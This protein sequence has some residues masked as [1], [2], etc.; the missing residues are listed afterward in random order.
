[1]R[2]LLP[3]ELIAVVLIIVG[4]WLGCATGRVPPVIRG[5][6]VDARS[7]FNR[8]GDI[9]Y[10]VSLEWD[11]GEVHHSES[12]IMDFQHYARIRGLAEVC[13]YPTV[14]GLD[15]RECGANR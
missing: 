12:V 7:V 14:Y 10:I 9:R 1:M 6:V 2:R 13:L 5:R 4:I 15:V 11:E 3:T 8:N